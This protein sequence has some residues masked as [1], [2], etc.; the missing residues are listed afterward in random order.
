MLGTIPRGEN[1]VFDVVKGI[2]EIGLEEAIAVAQHIPDAVGVRYTDV[3]W[4]DAHEIAV[5][6]V[7][8]VDCKG[9]PMFSGYVQHAIER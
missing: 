1:I 7:L 4:C 2:V 9:D 8:L 3:V 5:S 6:L